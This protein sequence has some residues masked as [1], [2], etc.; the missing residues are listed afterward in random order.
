MQ[1]NAR[2]GKARQGKARQG[3]VRQ[4]KARQGKA[5]QDKARQGKARQGKKRNNCSSWESSLEQ[6]VAQWARE[7]IH[8]FTLANKTPSMCPQLTS[9]QGVRRL[10][11]ELL[12]KIDLGGRA[13]KSEK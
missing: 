9:A 8:L 5:R 13:T 2:Q 1:C 4:G 12:S 7:R 6:W 3:K 10:N 11:W